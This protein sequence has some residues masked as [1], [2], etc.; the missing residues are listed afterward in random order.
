MESPA[1]R[2]GFSTPVQ[3]KT[4]DGDVPQFNLTNI[5]CLNNR[6]YLIEWFVEYDGGSAVSDVEISYAKVRIVN[7]IF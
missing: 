5:S 2:S 4:F 3:A 1:G 7:N 6:S